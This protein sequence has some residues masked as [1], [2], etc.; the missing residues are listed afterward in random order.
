MNEIGAASKEVNPNWWETICCPLADEY[1]KAA[2]TEIEVLESKD[3]WD[4]VNQTDGCSSIN[5][6]IQAE[7]FSQETQ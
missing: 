1:C 4:V 3:S 7:I 2:V 5:L 6:G